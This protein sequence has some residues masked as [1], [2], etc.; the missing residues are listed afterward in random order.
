[1]FSLSDRQQS[2]VVAA[3]MAAVAFK[4]AR[5]WQDARAQEQPVATSHDSR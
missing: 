3:L 5:H 2:L 4:A 1:M